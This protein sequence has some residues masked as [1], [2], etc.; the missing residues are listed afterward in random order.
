VVLRRA[1]AGSDGSGTSFV[2]FLT[3]SPETA[4]DLIQRLPGCALAARGADFPVT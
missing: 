3:R 4:V 2:L 1:G